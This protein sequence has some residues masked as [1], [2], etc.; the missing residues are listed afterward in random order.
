LERQGTD[1]NFIK[2]SARDLRPGGEPYYT[3]IWFLLFA[4]VPVVLN[5]TL[6]LIQR[7]RSRQ[8]VHVR[9]LRR[10]RGTARGALNQALM[11]GT[12]EPRK[13]YDG[14]AAALSRY[15]SDRFQVPE[16]AVTGDTL[17]RTLSDRGVSPEIVRETIS[18]LQD[19]DFGRFVS[20]SPEKMRST[21]DRIA[22]VIDGMERAS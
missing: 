3:K 15:L 10:A 7:E 20:S 22:R 6:F 14:A 8:S 12:K 4:T 16:I 18:C 2:L 5:L 9:R 1:I 21:A 19:C 11:A 13:F 17:E